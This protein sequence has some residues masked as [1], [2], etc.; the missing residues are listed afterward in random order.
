MNVEELR[1]EYKRKAVEAAR[2]GA[3][4][5]LHRVYEEFADI[6]ARTDGRPAR[7][8]FATTEEA[9]AILPLKRDTI[10]RKCSAGEFPGARKTGGE[11]G[12]WMIPWESIYAYLAGPDEANPGWTGTHG[13]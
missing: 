1:R 3:M 4:A 12:H 5:P 8:G 13:R 7:L 2:I 6:L 10:S 11:G 9:A